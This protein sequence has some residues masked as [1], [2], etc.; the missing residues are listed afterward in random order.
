MFDF[1]YTLLLMQPLGIGYCAMATS[2]PDGSHFNPVVLPIGATA[3][4][5]T[6]GSCRHFGRSDQY[7]DDRGVCNIS[8]PP[9][10]VER[11]AASDN[12]DYV[13]PRLMKGSMRC[14]L[15]QPTGKFYQVS[16]RVGPVGSA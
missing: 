4:P 13:T 3:D 5:D 1:F 7:G 8:L 11:Q 10:V 16:R 2:I 6:C 14:D 15:Q 9:W 12:D